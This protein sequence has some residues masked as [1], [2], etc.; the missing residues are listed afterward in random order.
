MEAALSDRLRERSYDGVTIVPSGRTF[1]EEERKAWRDRK[2]AVNKP[3][4]ERP[5]PTGR[6]FTEEEYQKATTPV[7]DPF[8]MFARL[9]PNYPKNCVRGVIDENDTIGWIEMD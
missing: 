8:S 5:Q 2:L 9:P 4:E 6:T 7:T 1:T 3:G